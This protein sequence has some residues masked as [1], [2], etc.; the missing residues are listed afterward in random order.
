MKQL[1]HRQTG[2]PVFFA[3]NAKKL[4]PWRALIADEA[5]L[6]NPL[7]MHGP[8]TVR[9]D[10]YFNPPKSDPY[11][12]FHTVKPDVDKL[13]RAVLDAL[14]GIVIHDDSQVVHVNA[15]KRYSAEP[16]HVFIAVEKVREVARA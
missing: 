1:T 12:V 9:L 13:T 5:R 11:R 6:L 2:K 15:S 3:D 10:F 4:K 7:K 8:V 16:P 14:K